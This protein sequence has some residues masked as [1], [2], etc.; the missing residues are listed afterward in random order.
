MQSGPPRSRT[1]YANRHPC[2]LDVWYQCFISHQ[3]YGH[4]NFPHKNRVSPHMDPV[5]PFLGYVERI[6][7]V[8]GSARG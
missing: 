2:T 5:Y 4:P 8:P 7:A 6:V 1:F 3:I